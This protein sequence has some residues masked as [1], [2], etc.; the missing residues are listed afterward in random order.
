M[1]LIYRSLHTCFPFLSL[2]A[3]CRRD[4]CAEFVVSEPHCCRRAVVVRSRYVWYM[5]DE[6]LTK[7]LCEEGFNQRPPRQHQPQ[8]QLQQAQQQSQADGTC[9]ACDEAKYEVIRRHNLLSGAL[10]S[11]NTQVDNTKCLGG[12]ALCA[13]DG[14]ICNCQ[15]QL[16]HMSSLILSTFNYTRIHT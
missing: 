1:Q 9:C 11:E 12:L 8:Q 16:K 15:V 7:E 5:D 13:L 10:R 14:I 3:A 4:S 6:G 2:G